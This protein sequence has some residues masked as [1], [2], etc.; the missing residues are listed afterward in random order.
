MAG[1]QV[2][3]EFGY[4]PTGFSPFCCAAVVRLGPLSHLCASMLNLSRQVTAGIDTGCGLPT[5]VYDPS[6]S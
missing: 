1:G 2:A 5:Q 4:C 6:Q 3:Y